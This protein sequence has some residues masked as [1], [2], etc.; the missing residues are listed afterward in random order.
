MSHRHRDP[1]TFRGDRPRTIHNCAREGSEWK[2]DS[3]AYS[4]NPWPP[5]TI[6]Q[7]PPPRS[8]SPS[9]LPLF[10]WDST[11]LPLYNSPP[12]PANT[13]SSLSPLFR[14]RTSMRGAHAG[15]PW[16]R[17][18][19]PYISGNSIIPCGC[20]P[21]GHAASLAAVRRGDFSSVSRDGVGNQGL[22][23]WWRMPLSNALTQWVRRKADIRCSERS[24]L[25][26]HLILRQTFCSVPA[27]KINPDHL[28]ALRAP[29]LT[30]STLTRTCRRVVQL[31][32]SGERGCW[33]SR[34]RKSCTPPRNGTVFASTE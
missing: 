13:Y 31:R 14:A 9:P 22:T 25:T 5:L 12:S 34:S 24:I 19:Y 33:A 28:P 32:M 3:T 20:Y 30:G 26:F 29:V 1:P 16:V 15:I 8:S 2:G 10:P 11:L 23:E 4:N 21:R 17:F 6:L 27:L 18:H 7:P